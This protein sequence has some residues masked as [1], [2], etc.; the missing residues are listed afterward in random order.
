MPTNDLPLLPQLTASSDPELAVWI[1]R[2]ALDRL[3]EHVPGI[4][5][6][7]AG[8]LLLEADEVPGDIAREMLR[9]RTAVSA[10]RYLLAADRRGMFI[11]APA[12]LEASTFVYTMV[13]YLRFG[14]W[15]TA[16]A[17]RL[18]SPAKP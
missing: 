2:H 18:Y 17:E 11:L 13:T 8:R 1:T 14:P 7:A 6:R 15:Q 3:G 9:R 10:D 16:L 4:T 12:E 5:V